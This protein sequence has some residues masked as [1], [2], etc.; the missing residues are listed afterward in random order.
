[1]IVNYN[2]EDPLNVVHLRSRA[3]YNLVK[4]QGTDERFWTFFHHDWYWTVLYPMSSL[5]V[6]KQYVDIE[7]MRNKKDMHFNKILEACDLHG[8]TDLLQFR[9]NWN[10]EIISEF[11]STLFCGKKER[12]FMWMTNGRRFHVK[13]AQFVHILGLSS[14][15]DIPK[16]LCSG[17]VM[18]PRV[19]TPMYVQDGGFQPPKVEGLLP[20]LLA[21]H[22]MMR[23]SLAPR[24]GYSE[25]IPAYDRNFLDALMKPMRFDVF[26][27]I[28]DEI[29]NIATNPL[30][31]CGFAPYIQFMIES[32]AQEKF[33]KDV[34]HDSLHPAV[35]KHPRDSR[36]SSSATPSRTTRSGGAPSTPATNSDMLKMLWGIFS[37]CRCTDQR[38]DVMDQCL[39]I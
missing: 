15:L 2:K 37:T 35:P 25:V 12:I 7:Y 10:Q 1:V 21:L 30:R 4:E 19:M 24:I 14:Q 11:Y 3:C 18:M 39:Q 26:E 27:Y 38:L 13:L 9:Y 5:V 16:K 20:H 8:I 34:R 22:W 36:A 6:K 29:W 31:S 32:M 17:Q 23:R 33:Y 28:V